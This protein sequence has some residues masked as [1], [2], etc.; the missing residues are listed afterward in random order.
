[1]FANERLRRSSGYSME[2]LQ[3][4]GQIQGIPPE[5][6]DG[7]AAVL[8]S[9]EPSWKGRIDGWRKSGETFVQWAEVVPIRDDSK[10]KPSF[11]VVILREIDE[12]ADATKDRISHLE[13]VIEA[14]PNPVFLKDTELRYVNCNKAYEEYFG[15]RRED[16]RGRRIE[17]AGFLD[18]EAATRRSRED[19]EILSKGG[20]VRIRTA[21]RFQ[22][23]VVREALLLLSRLQDWRGVPTGLLGV[24]VDITDLNEKEKELAEAKNRA[25]Q[26]MRTKTMFL[27]NMSHE[28]RTPLN[29]L[30]G[31]S[32]LLAGM[33]LGTRQRQ[34]AEKIRT[35]G[36]ALQ[37][38]VDEM[39]DYTRLEVG[40]IELNETIFGF[41]E[42]FRILDAV[43]GEKARTKGLSF[44]LE[45]DPELVGS[46]RC[47]KYRLGQILTN[48]A[49]NAVKFTPFGN[50]EIGC[51]I[52]D[53]RGDEVKIR[54]D[55]ADTGIGMSEEQ[56]GRLFR[57]FTQA[58]GSIT[59]R[60]GGTGLGL[61]ISS[62][63]VEIMGGN[64]LVDS[65]L[66]HGSIFHFEL[67]MPRVSNIPD[68]PETSFFDVV[69]QDAPLR[70]L[71]ILL[72]EDE[73]LNRETT[74]DLL[75]AEGANVL[76]ASSGMQ[77]VSIL[78]NEEGD[79]DI[80]L[81][82]IS[83]PGMTGLE[84]TTRIKEDRILR[85]IPVVA[86]TAH[87]LDDDWSTY[88]QAGFADHLLKP[89][90][91]AKLRET[92]LRWAGHGCDSEADSS[93][94]GR[95]EEFDKHG[96]LK[97]LGGGKGY[98]EAL[99]RFRQEQGSALDEI[100][101]FVADDRREDARI[102]ARRLR[103]ESA[104]I[105]GVELQRRARLLENGLAT[106]TDVGKS[107]ASVERAYTR[108]SREILAMLDESEASDNDAESVPPPD[109]ETLA[110][111]VDY[112]RK[113]DGKAIDLY[114]TIQ[115]GIRSWFGSERAGEFD[116]AVRSF[117]FDRAARIL[118]GE[119]IQRKKDVP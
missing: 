76:L 70:D 52:V 66:G 16:L 25:E 2:D 64:L 117:D 101:R 68:V 71:R 77:A 97:R 34:H 86:L 94:H 45:R 7:I 83:M 6:V 102:L 23:G 111:L 33:E 75:A 5:V 28:I 43:L 24:A 109:D 44:V 41:E 114:D 90:T 113:S 50:V 84:A 47:D 48:L 46:F 61:C 119:R 74:S 81:M 39:L 15:I 13:Q 19:A 98:I 80:V 89:Y 95:R 91:P 108:L 105:G 35:A 10:A 116:D 59:R 85:T 63:L 8:A 56:M 118:E 26:E 73:T 92:I 58:D 110:Q 9:G 53:R 99:L 22:D 100:A 30:V 51:R 87:V 115:Q 106:A 55:V 1:M 18:G 104:Y 31:M 42:L 103:A 54:F 57:P 107:L 40:Q 20:S 3:S 4:D 32:H 17:D 38:L 12:A 96:G 65:R 29:A 37:A 82:D 79:V 36:L 88:Q 67:W 49:G 11:I 60:F 93:T 112:L 69:V 78:Q 14:M 62:K 21:V 72:V 27:A